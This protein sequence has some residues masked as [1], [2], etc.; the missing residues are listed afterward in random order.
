MSITT[1]RGDEGLTDLLF[2]RRVSK[3]HP[4][5]RANGAVDELNAA[6]GLARAIAV[7]PLVRQRIGNLQTDL[8]QLMGEIATLP[9]DL[10]RYDELGR[11]ITEDLVDKA[12]GWIR[13]LEREHGVNSQTWVTPG[14][15]GNLAGAFLDQ[16]RTIGRRA[17]REV[18]ELLETGEIE[19]RAL[20]RYLN[21][22]SDLCW[23]LARLEEGGGQNKAV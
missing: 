12:H 9:E 10:P 16:A 23:L 18:A 6:L 14:A 19:N 22:V 4:R 13:E 3:S 7:Q 2:G 11:R 5:I 20:L 17:E 8:V 15:A 1:K 21:R